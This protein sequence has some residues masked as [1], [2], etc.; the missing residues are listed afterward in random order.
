MRERLRQYGMQNYCD[1]FASEMYFRPLLFTLFLYVLNEYV[2]GGISVGNCRVSVLMYADD[3]VLMADAPLELQMMIK[4]LKEHCEIWSL[5]VNMTK[6]EILIMRR[7]GGRR[8][9]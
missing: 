5:E 4:R 9:K 8:R 2:G 7:N 3:V 6:S 1:W